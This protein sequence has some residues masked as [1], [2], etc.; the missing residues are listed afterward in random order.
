MTL[1]RPPG[2]ELSDLDR[3]ILAVLGGYDPA[4]VW[5]S[6]RTIAQRAGASTRHTRR[7]LAELEALGEV[8]RVPVFER[9]SDAEWRRRGARPSNPGR[10][11]SN[12]YR[13]PSKSRQCPPPPDM[14]SDNPPAQPPGHEKA[15]S[16]GREVSEAEAVSK[17]GVA[18]D[19]GDVR[20]VDDDV[21]PAYADY[22]YYRGPGRRSSRAEPWTPRDRPIELQVPKVDRLD[23]DP[24]K[25]EILEAIWGG[26]GPAEVIKDRRHPTYRNS[27]RRVVDLET[28]TP[29]AL[30]GAVIDLQYG[31]GKR[32]TKPKDEQ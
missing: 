4:R 3:R 10:Q 17:A 15:M 26:L 11:T 16:G 2:R 22:R 19:H 29:A 9:S 5:P 6:L 14:A 8:E 13:L 18:D 28:C 1:A 27:Y 31:T 7:R 20:G 24:T 32:K 23:H 25:G 12:T 30:H 21:W